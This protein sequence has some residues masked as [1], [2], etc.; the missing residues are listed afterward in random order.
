M[1]HFAK[2]DD[3]NCVLE[4]L[5]VSNQELLDQNGQE[6][7]ARG[8]AFLTTWSGG[9]TRWK[10]TS[11]NTRGGVYH[12]PLPSHQTESDRPQIGSDQSLAFRGNYAGPGSIY[13][14]ENDVFYPSQPYPSWTISAPD[15]TWKPPLPMPTDGKNYQW[16]E[17]TMGWLE[18]PAPSL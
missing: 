10:Q 14:L 16:D 18:I 8:V 2:L 15:W 12:V 7:E 3:N 17:S 1:A 9:Y 6:S 5:V 4:V 11:Y 13:D